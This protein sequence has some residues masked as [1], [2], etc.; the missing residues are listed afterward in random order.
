MNYFS[1]LLFYP[2]ITSMLNFLFISVIG[3]SFNSYFSFIFSIR[4]FD[5]F[6]NKTS[7]VLSVDEELQS[8]MSINSVAPNP[9]K[10]SLMVRPFPQKCSNVLLP[11][12]KIENCTLD[13][14]SWPLRFS[15]HYLNS[16]PSFGLPPFPYVARTRRRGPSY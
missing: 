6:G 14:R 15:I 11:S 8:S 7:A 12:A 9:K 1:Q 5:H 3:I 16:T 4:Q 10:H 13:R 2:S